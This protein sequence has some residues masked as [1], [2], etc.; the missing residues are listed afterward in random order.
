M[1]L[2]LSI[3]II[4]WNSAEHVRACL[5]SIH[6]HIRGV[7]HEIIVVDN[8][9]YDGCAG[10][11]AR[12]H[13][14][15]VF[16]QSDHN[17]G[18]ARANNLGFRKSKGQALLFLNPDTEVMDDAIAVMLKASPDAGAVGC[19]LLNTDGSLQTSCVQAFPTIL[20]Q[21]LDAECLRRLCPRAKLWGLAP[22]LDEGA[23][24]VAADV[25]SGACLMVRRDVFESVGGFSEDFFMYG[26][27]IDLC[28]RIAQ[29]GRRNVVVK[30][31]SVVHHG[32][33]SSS[34]REEMEFPNVHMRE[35]VRL[36]LEKHHG[37]AYAA[38]YR[39]W[40]GCAAR[41]RVALLA[42][43]GSKGAG[44]L[45]KWRGILAWAKGGT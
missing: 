21:V 24:P 34:Q 6:R 31:V 35:S 23:E 9:S 16:I 13:A 1:S 43:A 7:S 45:G 15:A 8:A 41:V 12:D 33:G 22:I 36:F 28:Y 40:M 27:D 32:G 29:S 37:A 30:S 20:N 4:N 14:G 17:L 11:L 25:I 38:R 26:E 44:S 19:R 5:A 2:D 3:I 10:M 39:A 18:F 42:L